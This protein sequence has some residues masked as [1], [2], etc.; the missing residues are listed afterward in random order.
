MRKTRTTEEIAESLRQKYN[1]ASVMDEPEVDMRDPAYRK[2]LQQQQALQSDPF[3]DV[4][5]PGVLPAKSGLQF[6]QAAQDRDPVGMGIAALGMIPGGKQAG[7]AMRMARP[8]RV[9]TSLPSRIAGETDKEFIERLATMPHAETLLNLHGKAEAAKKAAADSAQAAADKAKADAEEKARKSFG[10]KLK[11][12]IKDFGKGEFMSGVKRSLGTMVPPAAA[13]YG[14]YKWLNRDDEESTDQNK[15]SADTGPVRPPGENVPVR[16]ATGEPESPAININPVDRLGPR[17][18]TDVDPLTGRPRQRGDQPP[19]SGMNEQKL[20]EDAQTEEIKKFLRNI[21]RAESENKNIKNKTGSNAFGYFQFVPK[22]FKGFVAR[23]TPDSPLYKKTWKDF[24]RDPLLQRETMKAATRYYLDKLNQSKVPVDAGSLYMSHHFGAETAARMMKNPN[25]PLVKFFPPTRNE[26]TGKLEPNIVFRQ[27]PQLSPTQ[28]VGEVHGKLSSRLQDKPTLANKNAPKVVD[29]EPN[30]TVDK[31]KK[32]AKIGTDILSTLAGAG[33]AQAATIDGK[34]T[35]EWAKEFDAETEKIA[36]ELNR[37][38]APTTTPTPVV[39]PPPVTAPK[40]VK[41]MA[42]P[43][44]VPLTTKPT[45]VTPDVGGKAAKIAG[46]ETEPLID[47]ETGAP[48]TEKALKAKMAAKAAE[49]SA[50]KPVTKPKKE[51]SSFEKEFA[52]ARARGDKTFQF[53]NKAGKTGTYSTKMAGEKD[54]EIKPPKPPTEVVPSVEKPTPT[55]DE[56]DRAMYGGSFKGKAYDPNAPKIDVSKIL[57]KDYAKDS[58]PG[59]LD[60]AIKNI[61]T[62]VKTKEIIPQEEPEE[63]S[64]WDKGIETITGKERLTPQKLNTVQVPESINTELNDILRLA[65]KK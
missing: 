8:P 23:A 10:G 11:Q 19:S 65:G 34:S 20:N 53:T 26:I 25:A 4:L 44:D 28:T 5:T 32:L 12:G 33:S 50:E 41:K 30:T 36:R 56:I 46:I 40:T 61:D 43:D 6:A 27:N 15:P 52:A 64:A 24:T 14:A 1:E 57:Q 18:D 48:T 38:S 49:K 35:E 60:T 47:P 3:S 42:S 22:T 62:P 51:P 31:K 55:A 29:K 63:K 9:P 59:K 2:K 21:G 39:P 54:T 17:V 45:D 16:P 7:T 37:G 13:A 58:L